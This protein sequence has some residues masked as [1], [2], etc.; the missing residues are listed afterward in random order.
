MLAFARALFAVKVFRDDDFRGQWRPEF[1]DQHSGLPEDDL[2]LLVGDFR[3][4][5]L[6]LNLIKGV[7]AGLAENSKCFGGF[8]GLSFVRFLFG[9]LFLKAA[10]SGPLHYMFQ[11]EL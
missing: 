10:H 1:R 11:L 7:D 6:P 8:H 9:A 3:R 5:F 4:A 2:V